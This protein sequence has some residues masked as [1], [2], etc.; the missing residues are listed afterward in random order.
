[1]RPSPETAAAKTASL[2]NNLNSRCVWVLSWIWRRC[3]GMGSGL[4]PGFFILKWIEGR[5]SCEE[6]L[7]VMEVL[8]R[9]NFFIFGNCFE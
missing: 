4:S 8:M 3:A 7:R 9:S 5:L 1:M 6:A 2:F